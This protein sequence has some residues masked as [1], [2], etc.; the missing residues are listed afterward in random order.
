MKS[1]PTLR[2]GLAVGASL[3]AFGL[4]LAVFAKPGTRDD[5]AAA[6]LRGPQAL[7]NHPWPMFG[8]HLARNMVNTTDKD[9]P[10]D[11]DVKEG[12]NVLWKAA[13]GSRAYG[14]P[15]IAGGKVFVGTN[16]EAPRNPA[17]EY[18]GDRGIVMCFDEKTGQFLWQAVHD[19]LPSGIV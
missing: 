12:K 4:V 8:G 14:G 11:V 18:Q 6:D 16:N 9:V 7:P 2:R 17:P 5:K 3:A 13:L 19:K 15:V 10:T 1:F